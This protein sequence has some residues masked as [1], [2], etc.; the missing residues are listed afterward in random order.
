MRMSNAIAG[1]SAPGRQALCK[2]LEN[3][4][5]IAQLIYLQK[6]GNVAPARHFRGR[7]EGISQAIPRMERLWQR[8]EKA[9][10]IPGTNRRLFT[11]T[12]I[13]YER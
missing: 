4:Y 3:A 7:S 5:T 9:R 12:Y 1:I 8:P 2:G 6:N 13:V 11:T 10:T